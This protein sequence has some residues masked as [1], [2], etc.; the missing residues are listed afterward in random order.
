[1]QK[2]N[3]NSTG[4]VTPQALPKIDDML[5]DF[6]NEVMEQVGKCG[7][8]VAE[9]EPVGDDESSEDDEQ[10]NL[11]DIMD[12]DGMPDMDTRVNAALR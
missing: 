11:E 9:A 3:K 6:V 10:Y 4:K 12:E 5:D 1:M 8:D 2:L 7:D